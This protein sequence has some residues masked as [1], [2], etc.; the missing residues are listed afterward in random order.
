MN[1]NMDN[2]IK[3]NIKHDGKNK[4]KRKEERRKKKK[5]RGTNL[6]TGKKE[7]KT[8]AHQLTLAIKKK[9]KHLASL[10]TEGSQDTYWTKPTTEHLS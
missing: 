8:Y 1:K 7:T 9:K 10:K 2:K 3:N 6:P 5:E 4:I